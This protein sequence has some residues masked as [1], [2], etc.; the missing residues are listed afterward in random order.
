MAPKCVGP[1]RQPQTKRILC[2]AGNQPKTD[3]LLTLSSEFAGIGRR[4]H[5]EVL[6]EKAATTQQWVCPEELAHST[7]LPAPTPKFDSTNLTSLVISPF[8]LIDPDAQVSLPFHASIP[9]YQQK[10]PSRDSDGHLIS[11]FP[12]EPM[13]RPTKS[14]YG[15]ENPNHVAAH[16]QQDTEALNS[17]VFPIGK[18]LASRRYGQASHGDQTPESKKCHN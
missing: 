14:T 1:P 8:S 3:E 18:P 4:A 9:E 10:R 12:R 7:L 2:F 17:P 6:R 16:Q 5:E 11:A 15:L 13:T